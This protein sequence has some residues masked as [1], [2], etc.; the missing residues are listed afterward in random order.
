MSFDKCV[1]CGD[2]VSDGK[3]SIIAKDGTKVSCS[4][5]KHC[6]DC[7][8]ELTTGRIKKV[9]V[10]FLNRSTNGGRRVFRNEKSKQ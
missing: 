6:A 8:I 1:C 5:K 9:S 4:P 7:F 3:I 2:P 10:S